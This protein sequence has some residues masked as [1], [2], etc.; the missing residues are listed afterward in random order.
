MTALKTFVERVL[1][2]LNGE[3]KHGS[4]MCCVPHTSIKFLLH[5]KKR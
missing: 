1:F 3:L 5:A 4:M 2:F